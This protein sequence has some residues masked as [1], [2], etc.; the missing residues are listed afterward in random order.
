MLL[1]KAANETVEL[2]TRVEALDS[3]SKLLEVEESKYEVGARPDA[4]M[5]CL[6]PAK[7]AI[8]ASC[9]YD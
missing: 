8:P 5:P 1:K 4:I 2:A 6:Q 9:L 3:L 7:A